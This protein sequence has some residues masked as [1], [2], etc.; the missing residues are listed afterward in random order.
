MSFVQRSAVQRIAIALT[1]AAAFACATDQSTTAPAPVVVVP[2]LTSVTV[3]LA[4]ATLAPG[5]SVTATA[6]GKDQTGAAFPTGFITWSSSAATVTTVSPAG[7]I[8]AIAAG[9]ATI[10]ATSGSIAG[11]SAV[12]VSAFPGVKLNEVESNGGAPG[13][14]VELYNPTT[15][16]IDISGWGFRDNDSTHVVYKVPAGTNIAAGAYYILEEA[17]FGF[18]LGAADEARLFNQFGVT[19][20]V[21]AWT[22]HAT[23][24]Y[25][26]CP[27]GSGSFASAA[28]STKSAANDCAGQSLLLWPGSD[29]V[30][31]VDG[32]NVFGTNGSGLTY[33]GAAAG[34]PAVLWAVRNNAGTLF[35]MILSGGIWTPDPTDNWTAGKALKYRNGTGN[36]DA[37]GVTFALGGSTAGMYVATERNNDSSTVS[38]NTILRVNPTST[39][40]TLTATNEWNIGSDLPVVGANLGIEAIT[41][42]PDSYLTARGFIDEITGA[43][44]NPANYADHGTGLF[45]V[46]VEGNGT[47]YAYALNHTNDTFKRVATFSSGFSGVMELA[48]D[49]ELNQ[50][51]AV[52]D[53]TC[54]GQHNILQ[55]NATSGSPTTGKFAITN[56]FA[57][58]TSM[59]NINNEGFS[60][61]P[62]SDCVSNRRPV[63]W[64]DDNET[65]GHTIRKATIP[66]TVFP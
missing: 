5:Q 35:R 23:I 27:N 30:T 51:W 36:P 1:A 34:T 25:A 41:W 66:C 63:F 28:S 38:R 12:T 8:A 11:T 3:T 59:P 19:V 61:A 16:A 7:V 49:R 29:D 40:A 46:G 20:E 44:Y 43:A 47:L 24:T 50:L 48:F 22:A 9:T 55:I 14:L 65:A 10:T 39:A 21:Y 15:A 17:Q 54:N 52:C 6:T 32:L 62:L 4:S 31:T 26:R 37:E 56:R 53:D 60:F 57:R 13:D 18:G 64:A 45:V 2:V 33:E 58:P 42:I